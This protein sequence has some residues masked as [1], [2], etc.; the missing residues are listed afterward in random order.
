ML[1]LPDENTRR[2]RREGTNQMLLGAL[3]CGVG[4][5]VTLVSLYGA[6]NGSGSYV[7]AWGAIV[8]GGLRC[9]RGYQL[10]NSIFDIEPQHFKSYSDFTGEEAPGAPEALP[11]AEEEQAVAEEAAPPKPARTG[12]VIGGLALGFLLAI[13][14]LFIN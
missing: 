9:Y 8:F 2:L 14:L 11:G 13:Y 1:P 12:L 3:I 10:R 7:V 6:S 5:V 4:L